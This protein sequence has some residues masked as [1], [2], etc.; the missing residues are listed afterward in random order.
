MEKL[1]RYFLV[2]IV[3]PKGNFN[4]KHLT[5]DIDR[6]IQMFSPILNTS[7]LQAAV[8]IDLCSTYWTAVFSCYILRIY[9]VIEKSFSGSEK[10]K[11]F[12]NYRS[13]ITK[14]TS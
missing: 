9:F 8:E 5:D 14:N 10:H 2:E 7:Q 12:L 11:C 4:L 13:I 3:S 1:V 6:K